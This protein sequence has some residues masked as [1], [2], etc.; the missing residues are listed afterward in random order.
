[1]WMQYTIRGVPAAID[2]RLRAL[3]AAEQRSLNDTVLQ[4]L[5]RA[6]GLSASAVRHRDLGDIAGTWNE[7]PA[8]DRAL[9]DQDQVDPDLWK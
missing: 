5:T 6:L 4:V 9:L 1:M 2:A 8:F 7:D 3:A